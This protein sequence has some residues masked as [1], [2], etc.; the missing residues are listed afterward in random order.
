MLPQRREIVACRVFFDELDVRGQPATS[1]D[2][3]EEIVTQ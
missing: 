2:A 1:E 3:L